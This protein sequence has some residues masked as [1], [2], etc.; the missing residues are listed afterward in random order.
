MLA[1]AQAALETVR[2][3]SSSLHP[4]LLDSLGLIAAIKSH[5][6]GF[7]RLTGIAVHMRLPRRLDL[8]PDSRIAV[9]RIVQEALT[10]VARHAHATQVDISFRKRT[11]YLNLELRDNGKGMA[12][13]AWEKSDALGILG[14]QERSLSLG[15]KLQVEST[16]GVGTCLRLRIPLR[17]LQETP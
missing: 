13:N 1:L 11:T 3:I 5:V 16:V 14:M 17:A 8:P 4:P 6:E 15:G 7:S 9:F 12:E 10:N 2:R